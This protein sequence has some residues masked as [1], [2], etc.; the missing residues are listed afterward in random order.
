MTDSNTVWD[1][2]FKQNPIPEVSYVPE[3]FF[4]NGYD[5][6]QAAEK[7]DGYEET[8]DQY[9]KIVYCRYDNMFYIVPE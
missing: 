9:C 3:T 6:V 2:Y 1:A 5:R 7:V 4:W 8:E